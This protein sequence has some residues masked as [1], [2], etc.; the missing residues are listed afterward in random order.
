MAFYVKR[1]PRSGDVDDWEAYAAFKHALS[2]TCG[3]DARPGDYSQKDYDLAISRY[4]EG[5]KL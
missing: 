4:C 3:W 1:A 2:R 5:A